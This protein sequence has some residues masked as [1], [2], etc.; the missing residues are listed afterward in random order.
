MVK[1]K[2]PLE[3]V[4]VSR[5]WF[6]ELVALDKAG[7]GLPPLK[8][9]VPSSELMGF[10][11]R[12]EVIG[13]LQMP[14]EDI[15]YTLAFIDLGDEHR[16]RLGVTLDV[17]RYNAALA[18]ELESRTGVSLRPYGMLKG[19][20]PHHQWGIMGGPVDEEGLDDTEKAVFSGEISHAGWRKYY[21]HGENMIS[22]SC[23]MGDFAKAVVVGHTLRLVE[24][25]G[26]IYVRAGDEL[27]ACQMSALKN[28]PVKGVMVPLVGD[29]F[30]DSG[31]FQDAQLKE[32]GIERVTDAR[33][34]PRKYPMYAHTER[35]LMEL[36]NTSLP[37]V[38]VDGR[39]RLIQRPKVVL[40]IVTEVGGDQLK[41]MA[42]GAAERLLLERFEAARCSSINEYRRTQLGKAVYDVGMGILQ[43]F[44]HP[45]I[46]ER[47]RIGS[48]PVCAIQ[49][50]GVGGQYHGH[51]T[52]QTEEEVLKDPNLRFLKTNENGECLVLDRR[53][54]GK[55]G[56]LLTLPHQ[57]GSRDPVGGTAT[58]EALGYDREQRIMDKKGFLSGITVGVIR[59][60]SRQQV[61]NMPVEEVGVAVV[62]IIDDTRR[63]E[64]ILAKKGEGKS[65]EYMR[66][67][68]EKYKPPQMDVPKADFHRY[69]EESF[70]EC[71]HMHL[72]E[73][74]NK[75]GATM[76]GVLEAG[77]TNPRDQNLV[78]NLSVC[79]G[80]TDTR[81]LADMSD[82][83]Q[84]IG[85]INGAVHHF[86]AL[87]RA[88]GY[89]SGEIFKTEYFA[90]MAVR[91]LGQ[92][93]GRVL[94]YVSG[95]HFRT[96]EQYDNF[97]QSS[98]VSG[99]MT[100]AWVLSQGQKP[101]GAY[102]TSDAEFLSC[103]RDDP[104]LMK[105]AGMSP[106]GLAVYLKAAASEN[107]AVNR[108]GLGD[109][110]LTEA[111]EKF[112]A[113]SDGRL[114]ST[115]SIYE[116]ARAIEAKYGSIVSQLITSP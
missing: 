27:T 111:L 28:D 46:R 107:P 100:D 69:I 75:L 98:M 89:R 36:C 66:F 57:E 93:A 11:R 105:K 88:A 61:P 110:S 44:P 83:N 47:V 73:F 76:N 35:S 48:L 40:D 42:E 71:R 114:D 102:H 4:P 23:V 33:G 79:G 115:P 43:S 20:P 14:R 31:P 60:F 50:K 109:I 16:R 108:E 41:L 18:M 116:N 5:A 19:L 68:V 85:L 92:G 25:V 1:G 103:L 94:D 22:G 53:F 29:F 24:D 90:Q 86:D 87:G 3:G 32:C 2:R 10:L 17:Y 6:D 58:L 104:S 56:I 34:A 82:P 65:N 80:I 77:L 8:R 49:Y 13:A 81:A 97:V 55:N 63:M 101:A 51:V 45:G 59:L 30:G 62:A 112:R 106:E 54:E 99:L 74:F 52:S 7:E 70:E 67:V 84:A 72:Q 91:F 95:D 113:A 96:G 78:N 12:P 15:D 21:S 37:V 38:V 39:L 9:V 26:F 64:D